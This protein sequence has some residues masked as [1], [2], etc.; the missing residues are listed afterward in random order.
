MP[1]EEEKTTPPVILQGQPADNA[2]LNAVRSANALYALANKEDPN[3]TA[4]FIIT[5]AA[6]SVANML[7]PVP[8]DKRKEALEVFNKSVLDR[9]VEVEKRIDEMRKLMT[10]IKPKENRREVA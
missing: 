5:A 4:N 10:T 8:L 2:Y 6:E 7:A 9:C 1:K 3:R